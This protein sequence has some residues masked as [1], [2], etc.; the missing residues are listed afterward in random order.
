MKHVMTNLDQKSEQELVNAFADIPDNATELDLRWNRLT[1]IKIDVL[2]RG[3]AHTPEKIQKIDF[4]WNQLGLKG[5]DELN[6]LFSSLPGIFL[7]LSQN[8]THCIHGLIW[9]TCDSLELI[10]SFSEI[11]K[12]IR[13]IDLRMTDDLSKMRDA[14]LI[15]AFTMLPA[16]INENPYA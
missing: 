8:N 6:K 9:N 7:D 1:H 12:N 11:S 5:R 16:H 14:D 15:E 4:R 10:T 3:F 2:V 13:S